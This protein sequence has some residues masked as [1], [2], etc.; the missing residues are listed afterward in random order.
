MAALLALP[1]T[2]GGNIR[3]VLRQRTPVVSWCI[4]G[5]YVNEGK[6]YIAGG[7]ESMKERP[8]KPDAA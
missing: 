6:V 5:D 4:A 3:T 2:T 7:V 1:V 8:W